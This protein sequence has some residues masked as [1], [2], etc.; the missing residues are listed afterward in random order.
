MDSLLFEQVKETNIEID[1]SPKGLVLES[2]RKMFET[3]DDEQ[4]AELDEFSKVFIRAA[5]Y[6]WK[7]SDC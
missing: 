7:Q 2:H 6:R 1:R 4:V 5:S 3:I